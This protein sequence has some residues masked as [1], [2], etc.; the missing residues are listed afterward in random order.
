M[1]LPE[2]SYGYRADVPLEPED[3]FPSGGGPSPLDVLDSQEAS[4]FASAFTR[5]GQA[6]RPTRPFSN[7]VDFDNDTVL[8]AEIMR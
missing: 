3:I 7:I 2:Y 6:G 4:V 5:G 8:L 1:G